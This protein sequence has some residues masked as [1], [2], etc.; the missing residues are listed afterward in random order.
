MTVLCSSGAFQ[1]DG[2]EPIVCCGALML[3]S[4]RA[5][6]YMPRWRKSSRPARASHGSASPIAALLRL[7]YCVTT[8]DN[9]ADLFWALVIGDFFS[10]TRSLDRPGMYGQLESLL[11]ELREPARPHGLARH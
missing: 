5:Q 3:A 7:S 1:F 4:A 2:R 6:P 11:N 8:A 10:G 9:S